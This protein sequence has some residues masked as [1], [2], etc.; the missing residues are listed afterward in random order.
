MTCIILFRRRLVQQKDTAQGCNAGTCTFLNLSCLPLS[1]ETFRKI[2]IKRVRRSI[3]FSSGRV[4]VCVCVCY[5]YVI[6][7]SPSRRR[8]NLLLLL[9]LI[10]LLVNYIF[11]WCASRAVVAVRARRPLAREGVRSRAPREPSAAAAV[12]RS[13]R[14]S[15]SVIATR[16]PTTVTRTDSKYLLYDYYNRFDDFPHKHTETTP[17]NTATTITQHR[18]LRRTP[19]PCALVVGII[20]FTDA[21]TVA[22]A[23]VSCTF[24]AAR[25]SEHT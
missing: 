20:F 7:V 21:T 25:R 24:N 1:G 8:R 3:L 18:R 12:R 11:L 13:S 17:R 6:D 2:R 16:R 23:T 15:Q 4:C 14:V 10:L 5:W 9:I 19:F 22:A